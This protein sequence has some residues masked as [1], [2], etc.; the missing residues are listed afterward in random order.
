MNFRTVCLSFER[1][2]CCDLC[3][4]LIAALRKDPG[5]LLRNTHLEADVGET[6]LLITAV[7]PRTPGFCCVP[8]DEAKAAMSEPLLAV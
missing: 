7:T 3:D 6:V 5:P 1:R 2:V 8:A 4:E